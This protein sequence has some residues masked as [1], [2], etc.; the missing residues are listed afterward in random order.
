MRC[1]SCNRPH[2]PTLIH[3]NGKPTFESLCSSCKGGSKMGYAN[4]HEHVLGLDEEPL[5]IIAKTGSIRAE[6]Y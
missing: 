3:R 6:S 2:T 5:V 4:T 1:T